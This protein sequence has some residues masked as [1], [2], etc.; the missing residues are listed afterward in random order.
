MY[1]ELFTYYIP[2]TYPHFH[3][4]M[5]QFLKEIEFTFTE[6]GLDITRR[7]EP[8]LAVCPRGSQRRLR[9]PRGGLHPRARPDLPPQREHTDFRVP[10]SI[11]GGRRPE[12]IAQVVPEQ[13]QQGLHDEPLH[14]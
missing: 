12:G 10:E 11:I 8:C 3:L 4:L 2:F 13:V 5:L 1:S 6:R 9:P 14:R 7:A